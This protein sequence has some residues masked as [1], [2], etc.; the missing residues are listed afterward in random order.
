MKYFSLKRL[1]HTDGHLLAF[2]GAILVYGLL[3]TPTPDRSGFPEIITGLLLVAAVGGW[4]VGGLF[5]RF[6]V[7]SPALWPKAALALLLY[8]MTVPLLVGVMAGHEVDPM[9]RDLIF[10][11]FLLL[12]KKRL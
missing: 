2:A 11:L 9:M 4:Q 1:L 10:F 12:L 8:G 7:L 3:G 6:W 5:R